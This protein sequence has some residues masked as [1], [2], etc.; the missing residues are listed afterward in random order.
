MLHFDSDPAEF[1]LST[2]YQVAEGWFAASAPAAAVRL[3]GRE[4]SHQNVARPDLAGAGS[5]FRAYLDLTR[6]PDDA[7]PPAVELEIVDAE[8]GSFAR[9][10]RVEPKL[11]AQRRE[12]RDAKRAKRAWIEARLPPAVRDRST[13]AAMRAL[14]ALPPGCGFS[15]RIADKRDGVSAHP[16]PSLFERY[17]AAE[18]RDGFM[19][20]DFGAGCRTVERPDIVCMEIFDY[21]STD[22]LCLGQALPFPDATFD[23]VVTLAVLEHVDDPFAC[24]REVVR[25]LKPGGLLFSGLPFLQPEH[26]YP[27]HFFNATRSGH[28]KLYGDAIRIV[29]QR[30]DDHQHP[31]LA[32]Q[33]MLRSYLLGLP[34]DAR[35]E[36]SAMSVDDLLRTRFWASRAQP[37]VAGLGDDARW[38]LASATTLVGRKAG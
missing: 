23:A 6:L 26:G 10:V 34:E 25:V 12:A 24:A 14:N 1:A 32:L 13:T 28:R 22:I 15:G 8:G 37:M 27:D 5:G 2:V 4:M 21:P 17:F 29:E 11:D 7:L 16:Y 31:F 9:T 3:H 18:P 19:A 30:V 35:R 20:L 36:M 38:E 33:W